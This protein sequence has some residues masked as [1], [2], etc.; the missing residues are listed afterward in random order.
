M[1]GWLWVLLLL[2]VG[3]G[4]V[5]GPQLLAGDWLGEAVKKGIDKWSDF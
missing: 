5:I 1:D 2:F 4:L 3:L